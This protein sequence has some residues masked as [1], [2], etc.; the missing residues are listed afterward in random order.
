MTHSASPAFMLSSH[1]RSWCH[2]G[3][4]A[5]AVT[6]VPAHSCYYFYYIPPHFDLSNVKPCVFSQTLPCLYSRILVHSSIQTILYKDTGDVIFWTFIE[7]KGQEETGSWSWDGARKWVTSNFLWWTLYGTKKMQ[8][9]C[10]ECT[11]FAQELLNCRNQII[12]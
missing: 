11:S 6:L 2:S 7:G 9:S 1:F 3:V 4:L 10:W 5:S 12:A 8:S